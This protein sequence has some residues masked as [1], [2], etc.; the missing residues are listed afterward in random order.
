MTTGAAK[1]PSDPKRTQRNMNVVVGILLLIN[2]LF[3]ILAASAGNKDADI[4]ARRA[5]IRSLRNEAQR[6]NEELTKGNF[7]TLE[8]SQEISIEALELAN[9]MGVTVVSVSSAEGKDLVQN[10]EFPVVT[11]FLE[12]RESEEK[13]LRFLEEAIKI[14]G[15]T[16]ILEN[17][18]W[19]QLGQQTNLKFKINSFLN[20]EIA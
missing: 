7:S 16:T 19:K 12:V 17:I 18:E 3:I 10:R 1:A 8:A 9:E 13:L 2:F 20:P 5:V 11:T 15:K 4:E 6:L 14:G